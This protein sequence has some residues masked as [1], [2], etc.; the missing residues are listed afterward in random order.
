[1]FF[2]IWSLPKLIDT[3]YDN[4]VGATMNQLLHYC[5]SVRIQLDVFE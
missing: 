3:V 4:Q 1:M 5:R 2:G